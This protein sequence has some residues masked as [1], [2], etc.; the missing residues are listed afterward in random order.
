[1]RMGVQISRYLLLIEIN[2][3]AFVTLYGVVFQGFGPICIIGVVGVIVVIVIIKINWFLSPMSTIQNLF[4]E[5]PNNFSLMY[6]FT[7][8]KSAFT[9]E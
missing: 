1:M 3:S 2:Q 6:C 8:I 7:T 4:L 9:A 5:K